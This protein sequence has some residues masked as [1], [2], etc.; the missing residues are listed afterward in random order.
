MAISIS[1]R[2]VKARPKS[3][4]R[5]VENRKETKQLVSKYN[6]IRVQFSD[7]ADR[8][9]LFT[10]KQ[11]RRAALLAKSKFKEPHKVSWVKEFWYDGVFDVKTSEVKQDIKENLLPSWAGRHN[12]IRV[13]LKD[14]DIHLLLSDSA[15][16]S[17]LNR[18][19]KELIHLPKV[20][21]LSDHFEGMSWENMVKPEQE[22]AQK[23][24]V[25]Q[26]TVTL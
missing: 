18:A 12:H 19:Q 7:G 23:T 1:G 3:E 6:H 4:L 16:R 15:V 14:K 26:K 9:F 25:L 10:D 20:S 22:K 21:W 8:H 13:N 24:S 11:L 5:R 17:S 2:V